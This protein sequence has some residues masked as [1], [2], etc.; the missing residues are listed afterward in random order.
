MALVEDFPDFP[1]GHRYKS[2]EARNLLSKTMTF[3]LRGRSNAQVW[4]SRT[5]LSKPFERRIHRADYTVCFNAYVTL[6]HTHAHTH[7]HTS[8]STERQ[9]DR[10]TDRHRQRQKHR[11]TDG[12][13]ERQTDRGSE[14]ETEKNRQNERVR[15]KPEASTRRTSTVRVRVRE[16]EREGE[17]TLTWL[18]VLRS[19][20]PKHT[21]ALNFSIAPARPLMTQ[22]NWSVDG[23]PTAQEVLDEH[24]GL[25]SS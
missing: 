25:S 12:Q 5:G 11:Q 19:R 13:A 3:D 16:R 10:R 23:R 15:V 8:R 2:E 20:A 24:L 9:V 22:V 14:R 18:Q 21:G 6:T 17:R 4:F 7:T 1:A